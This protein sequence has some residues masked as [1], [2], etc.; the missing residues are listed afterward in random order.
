MRAIEPPN[1]A[2]TLGNYAH[3]IEVPSGRKTLFIS[4]QVPQEISG[5]V[6]LGFT[7]Q[8]NVVWSN[9]AAILQEAGMTFAN[10]VKVNTFLTNRD[11]ADENGEIRRK[12]LGD[13]RPALTVVVVQTLDPKWLLEIEAIAVS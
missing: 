9:I 5:R 8:A 11:Q 6:P 3:A 4:G 7:D 13:H 12:F 2:P 1:I 10:L